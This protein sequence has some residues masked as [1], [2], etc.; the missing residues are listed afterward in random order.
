MLV[1]AIFILVRTLWVNAWRC[2]WITALSWVSSVILTIIIIINMI[3]LL[4]VSSVF[5]PPAISY[6]MLVLSLSHA[7]SYLICLRRV[8]PLLIM[9]I[10][11]LRDSLSCQNTPYFKAIILC[12]MARR[13][14]IPDHPN[15]HSALLELVSSGVGAGQTIEV[16][17]WCFLLKGSWRISCKSHYLWWSLKQEEIKMKRSRNALFVKW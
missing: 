1:M 15:H 12:R 5:E 6:G 8:I 14:S 2:L 3:G 13:S 11:T 9:C 4:L 7:C 16:E 17:G 10:Y